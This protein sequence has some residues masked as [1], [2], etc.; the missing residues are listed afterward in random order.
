VLRALGRTG[1][2]QRLEVKPGEVYIDTGC[3][4]SGITDPTIAVM[5][6]P[7]EEPFDRAFSILATTNDGLGS[8]YPVVRAKGAYIRLS[9]RNFSS[10][11]DQNEVV[12]QTF[13]T[14]A[15]TTEAITSPLTVCYLEGVAGSLIVN[16]QPTYPPEMCDALHRIY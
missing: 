10:D 5:S 16:G 3:Y 13:V 7:E 1:T 2:R 11:S 9:D 15:A 14:L 4:P 6:S 12:K 8:K